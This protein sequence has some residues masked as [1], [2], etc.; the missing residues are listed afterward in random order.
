[1]RKTQK[2]VTIKECETFY[3]GQKSKFRRKSRA[4]S[5]DITLKED[6]TRLIKIKSRKKGVGRKRIFDSKLSYKWKKGRLE[7]MLL[8]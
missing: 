1:M 5:K 6:Q 8:T 2:R 7:G 4:K 3:P